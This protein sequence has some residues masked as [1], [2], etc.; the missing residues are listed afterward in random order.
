MSPLM[1][2]NPTI[3]VHTMPVHAS[4]CTSKGSMCKYVLNCIACFSHAKKVDPLPMHLLQLQPAEHSILHT[5]G[6]GL[7][8]KDPDCL[9]QSDCA[10]SASHDVY[11]AE[12]H[13]V[14]IAL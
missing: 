6:L 10:I 3:P 5:G 9:A 13:A 14:F 1:F 11:T 4:A 12:V 2:V 8:P 7:I